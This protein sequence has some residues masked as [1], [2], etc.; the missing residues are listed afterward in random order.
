MSKAI[1][2][3]IFSLIVFGLL[4]LIKKDF[5]KF[6]VLKSGKE[7]AVVVTDI[8]VTCKI[9]NKTLHTYFEF[10]CN[11]KRYT[12]NL[13][14]AYC[15]S[16]LV[17]GKLKLKTNED[18]TIFLFL[19]ENISPNLYALSVLIVVMVLCYFKIIKTY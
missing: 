14:G 4:F 10:L 5:D 1:I 7:V 12:K 16:I 19:D 3:V 17:G 6:L 8:P 2:T 11:G 15:S 9:S 13:N 18:E